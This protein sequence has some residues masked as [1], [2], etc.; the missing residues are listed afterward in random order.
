MQMTFYYLHQVVVPWRF[1]MDRQPKIIL[2]SLQILIRPWFRNQK[3]FPAMD[4]PL[5]TQFRKIVLQDPCHIWSK[6][7]PYKNYL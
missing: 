5:P 1:V 3:Y 2:S 7:N 6:C 4:S